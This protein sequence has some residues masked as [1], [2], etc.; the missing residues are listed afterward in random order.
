[1][2]RW[3]LPPAAAAAAV[4][5]ALVVSWQGIGPGP[6]PALPAA[7]PSAT[8]PT[9]T[10]VA[11]AAS[12]LSPRQSSVAMWADGTFVVI[13]GVR[14]APCPASAD[15]GAPAFLRDGARYDPRADSWTRIADAPEDVYGFPQTT[16]EQAA[17]LDTTIYLLGTTSLLAYDLD[18]DQWRRLPFP[19][20]GDIIAFGTV[21]SA[22]VA[23]ATRDDHP[24]E[25]T[26]ATLRPERDTWVLHTIEGSADGSATSAT[27]AGDRLVLTSMT[28]GSPT[29]IWAVD[30]VDT[31]T[32]RL[33]R[34]VTPA[35]ETYVLHSI[36][37]STSL[38]DYA[39]WRG[40]RR[41]AWFLD[42]R[43][44]RWSDVDRPASDGAFVGVSGGSTVFWPV[45]VAGMV[46]VR[47]HL[48]DPDTRLWSA[49]PR[50]PTGSD[51][52]VV[53][54]G[55]DLVLACYGYSAATD[56]FADTC[57]LL[58]PGPASRARP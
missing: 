12:P 41:K 34:T 35:M 29:S 13:G 5:V 7:S 49:T 39:V 57:Y 52:P 17:V 32:A 42:T 47:G 21:D 46:E 11:T 31:T 16:L 9:D 18:T 58:R 15:C 24:G 36:A 33:T 43:T 40:Q 44:G 23:V 4:L 48:Y 37:L 55:P 26:F 1:R 2:E 6:V 10:W 38:T 51:S 14:S 53:T 20:G 50:L 25:V 45:T 3:W 28:T 54:S 27:V 22:V 30:T 56:A 19:P 8:L